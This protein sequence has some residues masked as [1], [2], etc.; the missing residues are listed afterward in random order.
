MKNC[1]SCEK[2]VANRA[3][4]CRHCGSEIF[5]EEHYRMMKEANLE[6][7]KFGIEYD[8]D[9]FEID[10]HRSTCQQCRRHMGRVY[11]ISG[12]AKGFP[13]LKDVPP[14]HPNCRCNGFVVP[15][16]HIEVM[17]YFRLLK[18]F[19]NNPNADPDEFAQ[20][21]EQSLV[22]TPFEIPPH[23]KLG[24][25][26]RSKSKMKGQG[27]TKLGQ[28]SRATA[29]AGCMLLLLVIPTFF[30]IATVFT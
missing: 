6:R 12:K 20:A 3:T 19:S 17:P 13:K 18:A 11:S 7:L 30:V 16:E 27:A 26:L 1:P 25:L 5:D 29:D 24:E 28:S 4:N 14:F 15:L 10:S 21:K 23:A 2:Q 9:L 22:G 8:M